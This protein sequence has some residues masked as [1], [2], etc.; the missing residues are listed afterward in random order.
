MGRLP[1][2]PLTMFERTAVFGYQGLARYHLTYCDVTTD[3]Q[4]CAYDIVREHHA[5]AV[6]LVERRNSTLSDAPRAVPTFVLDG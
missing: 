6:S 4:Q 1:G 5:L 2:L 3:R